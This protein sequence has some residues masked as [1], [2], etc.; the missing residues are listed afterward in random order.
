MSSSGAVGPWHRGAL[1]VTGHRG[2]RGHVVENTVASFVRAVELGATTLEL[3]VQVTADDQVVVWHDPV[4]LPGKCLDTAPAVPADPA[5]AYVGRNLVELTTDQLSTVDVGSRTQAEFPLQEARPG[6]RIPLLTEVLR[7]VREVSPDVWFLVELKLDPTRPELGVGPAEMVRAVLA[8]VTAA[9]AEHR[10]VLQSF[11][12]RAVAE[13]G[14]QAPD[15]PRAA[16][17]V[18]GLS[19]SPGSP[20]LGQIRFEDHGGDLVSAAAALGVG[21]ITPAW[22][23]P[24]GATS[25]TE[26]FR[27][28]SDHAFVERAHAAGLAVVPWTVND[29]ADLELV[30]G[31][32]VDGVITDYPDRAVR[33]AGRL[34][35]PPGALGG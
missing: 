1:E 14:R 29:E 23:T 15:L 25:T 28:V 6:A 20:W 3:D 31:A 35:D 26:G 22:A 13:A 17:A 12:W 34:L 18:D 24:Y 9:G 30:V 10:V 11:D 7:T 2:A 19:F 21:A 16:L 4:L 32:G 8:A 5:F 27:L 33:A